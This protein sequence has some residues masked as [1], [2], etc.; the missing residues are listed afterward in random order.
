MNMRIDMLTLFPESLRAALSES[1]CARAQESGRV[2]VVVTDIRSFANDRHRSAD[3]TP[4]GGGGGMV[5]LADVVA[6]AV[7]AVTSRD[8]VHVVLDAAGE[9]FTQEL[10]KE[11]SL[12]DHLVLVCGHYKGIDERVV[13]DLQLRPVSIG[14][15]VLTGGEP[16][17][18]V[19]ADS[20]IR[21][22][23][24]ALGD[25]E[26]AQGDS[27]F[28]EGILGPAVYTK[29]AQWRGQAVPEDLLSG[30]HARIAQWR[31]TSALERTKSRRPDLW[32]T[33]ATQERLY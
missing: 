25:F 14:D 4:Y 12:A 30:D 17:A 32:R 26:S 6:R 24:G 13:E 9:R 19:V 1:V 16:A 28:E 5:L 8:A 20:V 23:P 11:F 3:D 21:L 29:P 2:Q 15:F 31:R 27:F 22:I 7:E 10:S 33:I 18:W